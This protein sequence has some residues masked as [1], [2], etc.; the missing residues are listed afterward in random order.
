MI[1]RP[2]EYTTDV[3]TTV[4]FEIKVEGFKSVDVLTKVVVS[5]QFGSTAVNSQ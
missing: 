5:I 2:E 1:R 4:L 3:L